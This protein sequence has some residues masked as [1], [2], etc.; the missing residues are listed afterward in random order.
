MTTL[1]CVD[2]RSWIAVAVAP[3]SATPAQPARIRFLM[4]TAPFCE[5]RSVA[6]EAARRLP[7]RYG[8]PLRIQEKAGSRGRSADAARRAHSRA[9]RRVRR[10]R[11][12]AWFQVVEEAATEP[13]DVFRR[14]PTQVVLERLCPHAEGGRGAERMGAC[15]QKD[16]LV[17]LPPEE[18]PGQPRFADSRLGDEEQGAEFP[19]RRPPIRAIECGDLVPPAD[20]LKRR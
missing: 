2:G 11:S 15:R 13:A 6:V 3:T 14:K 18:L 19:A 9:S 7:Y 16:G 12:E 17:A 8:S 4:T 5:N 1:L 20:K 10:R